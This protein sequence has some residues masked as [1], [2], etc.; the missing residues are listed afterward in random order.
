MLEFNTQNNPKWLNEIMTQSNQMPKPW[1]D[2]FKDYG[3]LVTSLANIIQC[4]LLK[5][6]TPK[7][8]NGILQQLKGYAFLADKNTPENQA[9]FVRWEVI[10]TYFKV[11]KT[12]FDYIV[13]LDYNKYYIA[14]V[15]NFGAGHYIN[16]L[17]QVKE[18]F[19][20]FDVYDG[21]TKIYQNKDIKNII[22][23]K[24]L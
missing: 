16:I 11:K 21:K 20:C 4:F 6:F 13:T 18:G 14:R 15:I 7:D 17:K 9:S 2:Y 23:I 10:E 19:V 12:M 24:F 22:E 3:C 5:E 1:I 8:L